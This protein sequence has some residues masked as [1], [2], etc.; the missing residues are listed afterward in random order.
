MSG[1]GFET[2]QQLRICYNSRMK[3]DLPPELERYVKRKLEAGN[4]SSASELLAH[5]LRVFREVEKSSAS[6]EDDLRREVQIGLD[7]LDAGR[8]SQW[9]A[10]DTKERLRQRLKKRKAS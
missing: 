7:D 10:E 1:A 9:D 6:A 5:A 4:Y 2:A 3:I 8:I